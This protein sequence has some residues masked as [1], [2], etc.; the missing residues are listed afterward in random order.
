MKGGRVFEM[1]RD[2]LGFGRFGRASDGRVSGASAE[3]SGQA[4]SVVGNPIEM[5]GGHRGD[6]TWSA[7]ATLTAVGVRHSLLNSV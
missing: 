1:R 7:E 3:I 2:S 5:I 6:E 4:G